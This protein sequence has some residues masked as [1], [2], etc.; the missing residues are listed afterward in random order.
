MMPSPCLWHPKASHNLQDLERGFNGQLTWTD[1]PGGLK[2]SPAAFDETL[3]E[4][5]LSARGYPQ[6]TLL[7]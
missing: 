3:H 2:N 4:D 1:L 7:Q 5:L 6:V